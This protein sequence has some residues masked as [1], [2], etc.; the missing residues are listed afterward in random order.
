MEGSQ[1]ELNDISQL[2]SPLL[3][4][5]SVSIASFP[6]SLHFTVCLLIEHELG[7]RAAYVSLRRRVP[8]FYLAQDDNCTI[9]HETAG[10]RALSPKGSRRSPL[11]LTRV[12]GRSVGR[13]H[14]TSPSMLKTKDKEMKRKTQAKTICFR[15][16]KLAH[17]QRV[18]IKHD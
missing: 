10:A 11:Q 3:S 4:M 6:H 5:L 8:T 2:S 13:R 7:Y 17:R 15:C 9:T 12:V 14:L 1:P 16:S 18:K